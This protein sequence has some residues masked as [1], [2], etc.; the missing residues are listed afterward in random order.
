[1]T[2]NVNTI[3]GFTF[4]TVYQN[5]IKADADSFVAHGHPGGDGFWVGYT[6]SGCVP[7]NDQSINPGSG[8]TGFGRGNGAWLMRSA[9]NFL[10]TGNNTYAN[11]V[12]T[13]LLSLIAQA[14]LDWNNRSKWCPNQLGGANAFEI[15]PWLNRLDELFLP[16]EHCSRL[17][18]LNPAAC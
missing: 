5:R 11:P 12:R 8:G 14:G 4:Q 17:Y 6:G 9:F 13:E 1:M 7:A 18:R 10:L 16:T 15:V 3:N 2:D